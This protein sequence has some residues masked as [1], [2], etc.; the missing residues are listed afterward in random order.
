M[1]VETSLTATE[2]MRESGGPRETAA[3]NS[4]KW[5]PT[6]KISTSL[7]RFFTEPDIENLLACAYTKGRNPTPWTIPRTVILPF[8]REVMP[9]NYIEL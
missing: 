6:A 2:S 4:G 1:S 5:S 9:Q 3:R 7:P 8:F